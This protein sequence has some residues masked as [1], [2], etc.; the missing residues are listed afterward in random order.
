MVYVQHFPVFLGA[1]APRVAP[2][3][4][5]GCCRFEVRAMNELGRVERTDRDVIVV[6]IPE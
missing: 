4:A 6:G 3:G 5:S 2:F 1:V